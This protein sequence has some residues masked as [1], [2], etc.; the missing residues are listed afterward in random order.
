M[1]E[2]TLLNVNVP[3]LPKEKIKGVIVTSQG[4][5]QYVDRYEKRT[6]PHGRDYFWLGGSL[7]DSRAPEG[8]DVHAIAQGRISITPLQLDMTASDLID[9][10]AKAWDR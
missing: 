6:D 9:D 8:S 4:P 7:A 10:L 5:R 1:P 2:R 3:N